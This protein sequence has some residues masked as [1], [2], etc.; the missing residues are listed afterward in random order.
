[1]QAVEKLR[2]QLTRLR[3]T[4]RGVKKDIGLRIAAFL[5]ESIGFY[6]VWGV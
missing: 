5:V 4:V 3:L 2:E 6:E 1:M